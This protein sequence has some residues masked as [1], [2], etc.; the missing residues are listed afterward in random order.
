LRARADA[1][2]GPLDRLPAAI[3]GAEDP[4]RRVAGF[5]TAVADAARTGDHAARAIWQAAADELAAAVGAAAQR[6]FGPGAAA[7]V[8][9]AGGLFAAGDLL[10]G[11]FAARLA[12][13][14]AHLRPVP[15]AGMA[16]DGARV[17]AAADV[18]RLFPGLIWASE[19]GARP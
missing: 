12:A 7:D 6:A 2:F 10:H 9:W 16:L 1:A 4:A 15:P 3:Y 17:L 14:A 18:Q 19:R 5:A 13:R 8:S 11:P